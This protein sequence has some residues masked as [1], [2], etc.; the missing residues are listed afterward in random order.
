MKETEIS[1]PKRYKPLPKG[2]KVIWS[3][4]VEH[5]L[6]YYEPGDVYSP[7]CFTRFIARR[8]CFEFDDH[9]WEFRK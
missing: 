7:L 1:F 3:E 9:L 8:W 4:Y 6:G 2:F 5:Y